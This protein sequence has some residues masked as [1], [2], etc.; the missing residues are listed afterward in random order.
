MILKFR[1]FT[2]EEVN[3]EKILNYFCI[4]K[5]INRTNDGDEYKKQVLVGELCT[6]QHD[7]INLTNFFN[8]L[9]I[10]YLKYSET[11]DLSFRLVVLNYSWALIQ[12]IISG[13]FCENV[14]DYASRV[15]E[16]AKGYKTIAQFDQSK[17][18]L[19]CCPS[20]TILRFIYS[21]KKHVEVDKSIK[22]NLCYYFFLLIKSRSFDN[23]LNTYEAIILVCLSK[24]LNNICLS[25][26][27]ILRKAMT[28]I[29]ESEKKEIEGFVEQSESKT[30]K[31]KDVKNGDITEIEKSFDT[32]S[33]K[34]KI[35]EKS[36]FIP[37]F[38]K[39][40]DNAELKLL[41]EDNSP[42]I[43][44]N[45]CPKFVEFI[46]SKYMPFC[47]AWSSFTLIDLPYN[48]LTNSAIDGFNLFRNSSLEKNLLPHIYT[49]ETL[50]ITRGRCKDFISNRMVQTPIK[51]HSDNYLES[52][53][54]LIK[55][56]KR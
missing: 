27:E 3:F 19:F 22:I 14:T 50:A 8:T 1:F 51:R 15:Y 45:Y 54:S 40:I 33:L 29:N 7:V 47:F 6:S 30:E 10:S 37:E 23:L 17:S 21:M 41:L 12:S 11:Y 53:G 2:N 43:N 13:I 39:V 34:Y 16:L 48:R 31:D 52:G 55:I 18:W 44:Q 56:A 36:L 20:Q 32:K 26:C 42:Q 9:R 25:S 24:T 28:E 4:L 35:Q 46:N 38:N 49:N 5:K